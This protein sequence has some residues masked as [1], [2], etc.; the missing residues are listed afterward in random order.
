[1]SMIRQGLLFLYCI[2]ITNCLN[3]DEVDKVVVVVNDDA[4]TQHD[5][6]EFMQAS[7]ASI[8]DDKRDYVANDLKRQQISLMVDQS[9]IMGVAERQ[10][11]RATEEMVNEV[12]AKIQSSM[13]MDDQAFSRHLSE[14]N[15]SLDRFRDYL[16]KGITTNLVQEAVVRDS[17]HISPKMVAHH[18]N[19]VQT[20]KTKYVFNDYRIKK[21]DIS[22]SQQAKYADQLLQGIK[23]HKRIPDQVKSYVIRTPFADVSKDN[24]PDVLF[25]QLS[26]AEPPKVVGPFKLE[27]GYHVIWY[28]AKKAPPVMTKEQ[29]S[30]EIVAEKAH[31]VLEAWLKHLHETAYIHAFS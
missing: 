8:P 15:L 26:K 11:I 28:R 29:A 16:A 25:K 13:H 30:Q 3:A 4:I 21:N 7:L 18:I 1:M 2:V 23:N 22:P 14:F 17:L 12:Q 9:L 10:N 5:V 6:N 20:Q 27:N 19:Q 31:E 24:I